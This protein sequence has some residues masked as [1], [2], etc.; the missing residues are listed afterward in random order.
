MVGT[1]AEAVSWRF[2]AFELDPTVPPG[3]A[4]ARAYLEARY[5]A[6]AVRSIHRR[7][8]EVA[9]ADGLPLADLEGVRVRPNTFA[10]HRLMTAALAEGA[11]TQW[12]L[13]DELFRAY[14]VDGRDVGDLDVLA[15]AGA[16]AGLDEARIRALLAGDEYGAAVRREERA[17]QAAGIHA[18]PTFVFGGYTAVSGAQ[19]VEVLARTVRSA[20]AASRA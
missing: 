1:A 5:D 19:P 8:A 11:R 3:G 18:V 12:A 10:A 13:A 7:L 4:D 20:L 2:G 15:E 14:W 9:A 6:A 17:A 16:A